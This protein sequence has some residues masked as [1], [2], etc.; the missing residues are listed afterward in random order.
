MYVQ[1][2]CRK[3]GM[4]DSSILR[5][6]QS[7]LSQA[8]TP[9]DGDVPIP[10][11]YQRKNIPSWFYKQLPP[12]SFPSAFP[13][14]STLAYIVVG[15]RIRGRIDGK[16]L[17]ELGVPF[18]ALRGKLTRGETIQFEVNGPQGPE[19]R[20]VRPEDC[21]NK[22]DPPAAVIILD[23]PSVDMIPSVARSFDTVY[24]PFHSPGP[25]DSEQH[26]VRVVYHLLGPGVLEDARYIKFL[27]GFPETVE[28]FSSSHH[29]LIIFNGIIYSTSYHLPSTLPTR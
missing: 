16:K 9:R 26:A 13:Q 8:G 18:N 23:V 29:P 22:S 4:F 6:Y 21:M 5:C 20:A 3:F 28:V 15:P 14:S 17:T 27:N 12:F 24:K 25:H 2:V 11:E 10:D 1:A 19:I 7:Y